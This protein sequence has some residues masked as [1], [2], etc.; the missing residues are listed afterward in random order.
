[1]NCYS[2]MLNIKLFHGCY[3]PA[4]IDFIAKVTIFINI[5]NI[6][7]RIKILL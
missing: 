1:M 3:I 5:F 7:K 6:F 4:R 2:L